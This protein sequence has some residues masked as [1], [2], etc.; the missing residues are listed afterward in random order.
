MTLFYTPQYVTTTLSKAGGLTDAETTGIVLS[1]TDGLDTA[2]P[3]IALLTYQDP[4]DVTKAEWI[5]YTSI[6]VAKELV[7]VARAAEGS[8]AKNHDNGCAIAFPNSKSHINNL[9][10]AMVLEHDVTG[11]HS[12]V[13]IYN[14]LYRQA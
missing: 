5:T 9:N 13:G 4:L 10:D 8:T 14:S 7:G 6:S 2:K 3:S 12:G 1:S 11:H